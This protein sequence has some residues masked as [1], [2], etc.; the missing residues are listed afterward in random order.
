MEVM[1]L[2]IIARC[3]GSPMVGCGAAMKAQQ[4][5]NDGVDSLLDQ[6]VGSFARDNVLSIFE[7]DAD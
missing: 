6:F 2:H 3:V 1:K 5:A 4:L 7:F